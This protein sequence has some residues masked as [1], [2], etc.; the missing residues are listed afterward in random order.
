MY[1]KKIIRRCAPETNGAPV[2][3]QPQPQPQVQ[4][5]TVEPTY[6]LT[7]DQGERLLKFF[8]YL[9]TE[10]F[11]DIPYNKDIDINFLRMIPKSVYTHFESVEAKN[12]PL[13]ANPITLLYGFCLNDINMYPN[14]LERYLEINLEEHADFTEWITN[15]ISYVEKDDE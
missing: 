6:S 5:V 12:G 13:T 15:N 14:F 2:T 4:V 3:P 7:E 1:Y 11:T 9:K 10:C 8:E